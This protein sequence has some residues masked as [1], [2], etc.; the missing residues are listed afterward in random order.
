[1]WL[2]C[3]LVLSVIGSKGLGEEGRGMGSVGQAVWLMTPKTDM[4]TNHFLHRIVRLKFYFYN[5]KCI[6]HHGS[7]IL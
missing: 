6:L 2:V 3:V 5:Y 7:T 1:M 4:G